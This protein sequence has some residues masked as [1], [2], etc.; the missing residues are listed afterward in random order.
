MSGTVDGSVL[1]SAQ[2]YTQTGSV[3]GSRE[4]NISQP[5]TRQAPAPTAASRLLD[6]VQRYL[7]ILLVGALCLWAAP[8]FSQSVAARLREGPLASLGFG[9]LGVVGLLAL[10]IGLFIGMIVLAVPLG[11]L[12]FGRLVVALVLGVLLGSA[13][14]SYLFVLVALFLAAAIVGL[15]L[16]Q[17]IL[18]RV[19]PQTARTPYAALPL[20][21]VIVVALTAIPVVGALLD[22]AVVLLGLGAI[23]L[24]FRK[25]PEATA[26]VAAPAGPGGV[27]QPV[28][29]H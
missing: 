26:P 21:L 1:G 24:R 19:A 5:K 13:A 29:Q 15:T 4:V 14:L 20:G 28:P 22:V 3:G 17:L 10:L 12:G 18:E 8:K 16:G 11:L 6:Q 7:G 27:G 23:I 25:R 9:A 2:S